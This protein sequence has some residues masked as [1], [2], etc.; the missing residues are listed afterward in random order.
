MTITPYKSQLLANEL[1]NLVIQSDFLS[2]TD[3]L[4]EFN[5][6]DAIYIYKDIETVLFYTNCDKL[7]CLRN[8]I[9]NYA[10]NK[11]NG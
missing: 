2:L 8:Y 6:L 3:K 4:L 10:Q 11:V 7:D 5:S 1:A 9:K